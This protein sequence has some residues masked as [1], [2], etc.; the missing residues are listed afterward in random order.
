MKINSILDNLLDIT[1]IIK[2]KQTGK[3]RYQKILIIISTL[4]FSFL[5]GEQ[6]TK[7]VHPYTGWSFYET[8]Q[9]KK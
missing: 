1:S 6:G 2:V 8:N 4:Y 5:F 7:H 9:E 3:L